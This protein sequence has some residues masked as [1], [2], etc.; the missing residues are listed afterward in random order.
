MQIVTSVDALS[1]LAGAGVT[2]GNF[3]GV[4]KGHQ[5]LILRTLEVCREQALECVV[6]TFWPHPRLVLL[7][8]RGHLPL[9][10]REERL[11]LL[12]GLGARH[13]LELPFTRELAALTPGDFVRRFLLPLKLRELV[14]GYDFS[15][16]R[17]RSGHAEVLRA[18]GARWGFGV[19]QLPPV[20]VDDAVVSSTRLRDLIRRGDVWQAARL[21]GRFYGFSGPVVHGEGRGSGLG[22]PTANLP[23]PPVLLP[24]EGVYA[25]RVRVGRCDYQAVTNVGRKPTFGGRELCIESFLLDASENLYGQN[26]RLEFMARLRDEQRFASAQDLSRQI[27]RDVE[28]T[29][30]IFAQAKPP[31][32]DRVPRRYSP[33]S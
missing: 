1:S 8:E 11:D 31:C 6:L 5:A 3:D 7:P 27:A 4:H 15:L 19:E 14:V 18:L 22:F 29:R 24:A 30:R 33:A 23:P 17:D 12:A 28:E 2:I 16:G 9:T 13:V 10:S 21:L 20:I 25:A 26:V 32:R